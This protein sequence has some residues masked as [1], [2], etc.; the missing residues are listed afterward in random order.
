[1]TTQ[2]MALVNSN[3]QV[4]NKIIIDTDKPPV[5]SSGLSM[6][7]WTNA[8]ETAYQEYLNSQKVNS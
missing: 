3:G 8:D 4:I 2:I 7:E 6:H 5:L 1:M